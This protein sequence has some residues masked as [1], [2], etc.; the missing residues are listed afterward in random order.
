M[1]NLLIERYKPH[2]QIKNPT[3]I[4]FRYHF[5]F[6]SLISPLR[7]T[8]IDWNFRNPLLKTSIKKKTKLR[9]KDSYMLL[10]WLRYL[11][12][13][14]K[15]NEVRSLKFSC[16]PAKQ[17]V[18]SFQ[19][20]PMAHKT[21]SQQHF[22]FKFFFF[23]L[24]FKAQINETYVA[25]NFQEGLAFLFL[26]KQLFPFFETNLLFLKSYKLEFFIRNTAPLK[27]L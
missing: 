26:I 9:L 20:A 13:T 1:L 3:H 17:K 4:M 15:A 18:Y 21:N 2:C 24:S 19:K 16:L 10:S 6:V 22:K 25:S 11:S 7:N 14:L 12:Y 23:R 27:Y 8:A 5:S